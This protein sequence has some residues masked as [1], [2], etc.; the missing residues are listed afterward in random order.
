MFQQEQL[1]LVFLATCTKG[2]FPT[3]R[4]TINLLRWHVFHIF[5]GW[6]LFDKTDT[7]HIY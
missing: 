3:S 5:Q 7:L 6:L 4:K 2:I 1:A